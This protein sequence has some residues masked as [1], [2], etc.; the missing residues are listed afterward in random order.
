MRLPLVVLFAL[1]VLT[2]CPRWV[3]P[4]LRSQAGG[5]RPGPQTQ[6]SAGLEAI[7]ELED[8]RSF[9]ANGR[10]LEQ[11]LTDREPLLRK[12]ALLALGRIQDPAA[13]DTLV[14]GLADPDP[15]VRGEAAF[16]IGLLGLSWQ[17]LADDVKRKLGDALLQAEATEA[18]PTVRLALL[19][20]MGRVVTPG[21]QGRLVE[22]LKQPGDVQARAAL[23]LGVGAKAVNKLEA[24]ALAALL[25]LVKKE[26]AAPTRYGAAYALMQSK[27]PAA[28]PALMICVSDDASEIRAI[29]AKGLGEVGTDSD[30]VMLKGLID[31]PDYRVSVEATRALAKLAGGCKTTACPALG[32]LGDLSLR[33]D[34]LVR[35]D[36]AGGGQPLL[37]LAQ[38]GLPASGRALLT[39]LRQQLAAAA[40]ATDQRVKKDAANLDCRLA[41]AL[42]RLNGSLQEVLTCGNGLIDESRRLVLG[43]RELAQQ[44]AKDPD[45]RASEVASFVSHPDSKVKLA[46]IELLGETKST[47]SM[48]KVRSQL[49][50]SD[51]VLA[52]AAATAAAKLGDTS[53]IPQIR[54]LAQEAVTQVDVAPAI[55]DALAK[56]G[57]KDAIVD[58]ESWLG[59]TNAT[60][61]EA[62]AAALTALKGQPVVA[63]RVERPVDS[64]QPLPLP[65]DAAIVF[66]TEKGEFEVKLFDQDAPRTAANIYTLAKRGFYRGLTFHRVVPN[67]VVQGG[68]P[69]GD[70]EGGPGYTI[71]CEVNHRPYGR[72]VVGMALSGKDTGGSQFFVTAAPQPHL[73]GRYT[74][75]GEV[76][77]GQEVVDALL[78]GDR[79]VDVRTR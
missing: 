28:R 33:I 79:I 55:A 8:R 65:K 49:V 11:A 78:E 31:D 16:S 53:A 38:Q 12:R 6:R 48:D 23:S 71:R 54:A 57:A 10:L 60:V 32:A 7:A 44:P 51:R 25:P 9:G 59:S 42:D 30:A 69:R 18:D 13:A 37:A 67:F 41:A 52:A 29:C 17:P 73:D 47:R 20:A 27:A 2:A 72:G 24:K 4:D 46:A 34:R 19:E 36:T 66:T 22:R 58:L 45:K 61:R 26:H 56:L 43:L 64:V 63:A 70:G 75:F 5:Q 68:D 74:A 76:V 50:S 62:A 3:A 39:R 35:G 1:F 21:T 40:N 77:R 15:G 14:K